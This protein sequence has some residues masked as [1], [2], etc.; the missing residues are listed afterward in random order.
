MKICPHVIRTLEDWATKKVTNSF[1]PMG[2]RSVRPTGADGKESPIADKHVA[3]KDIKLAEK[4]ERVKTPQSTS[5]SQSKELDDIPKG[6]GPRAATQEMK[7]RAKNAVVRGVIPTNKTPLYV[8]VL[9]DESPH[10]LEMKDPHSP[11]SIVSPSVI[12]SSA[13]FRYKSPMSHAR[14]ESRIDN[15]FDKS[16][17]SPS[18]TTA[19]NKSKSFKLGYSTFYQNQNYHIVHEKGISNE[20]EMSVQPNNCNISPFKQKQA[21]AKTMGFQQYSPRPAINAGDLKFQRPNHQR[22]VTQDFLP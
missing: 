14:A 10:K 19:S 9:T 4:F 18:K 21:V 7:K 22:F 12:P 13:L 1:T 5:L 8:R 20:H 15:S 3:D 2:A 16:R 6:P 11:M 17:F